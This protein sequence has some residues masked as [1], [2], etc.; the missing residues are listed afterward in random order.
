LVSSGLEA[1]AIPITAPLV[2]AVVRRSARPRTRPAMVDLG[3]FKRLGVVIVLARSL[4]A[5]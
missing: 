5:V 2:T 3:S 4:S 1:L